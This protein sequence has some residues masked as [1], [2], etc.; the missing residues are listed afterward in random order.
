MMDKCVYC[1]Y[2][3]SV[4]GLDACAY[5]S[6]LVANRHVCDS[7]TK[8]WSTYIGLNLG[9]AFFVIILIGLPIYLIL[10]LLGVI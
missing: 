6:G 9:I 3:S 8:S 10:S 1:K 7:Y 4:D 2:H 5:K